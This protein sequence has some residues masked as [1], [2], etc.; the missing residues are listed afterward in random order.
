MHWLP[1]ETI[2]SPKQYLAKEKYFELSCGKIFYDKKIVWV[3]YHFDVAGIH[4]GQVGI[5]FVAK[6]D[7][8]HEQKLLILFS[9]K[10]TGSFFEEFLGARI[11]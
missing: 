10:M 9:E 7:N 4:I 2:L 3:M 6:Q 5:D 11:F 1:A 8:D